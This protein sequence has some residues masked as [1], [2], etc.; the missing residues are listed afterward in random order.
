MPPG[1]AAGRVLSDRIVPEHDIAVVVGVA[2]TVF[3]LDPGAANHLARP[4]IAQALVGFIKSTEDQLAILVKGVQVSAHIALTGMGLV[5]CRTE[6]VVVAVDKVPTA[7][8]LTHLHIAGFAAASQQAAVLG[9]ADVDTVLAEVVVVAFHLLDASET[10]AIGVVGKAA[11]LI[12]PAALDLVDQGVAVLELSVG[13]LEVTACVLGI[14]RVDVGVQRKDFLIFLLLCEGVQ[15]AGAHEDTIRDIAHMHGFHLVSLLPDTVLGRQ[16]DAVDNAQGVRRGRI[17]RCRLVDPFQGQGQLIGLLVEFSAAQFEVV[18]DQLDF[19]VIHLKALIEGNDR[20]HPGHG[21]DTLGQLQQEGPCRSAFQVCTG[22]HVGQFLQTGGDRDLGHIQ[23]DDIGSNHILIRIDDAVEAAVLL[24]GIGHLAHPR[25]NTAAAGSLFK[26]EAVLALFIQCDIDARLRAGIADQA[27]R[28]GQRLDG[29][30]CR[31]MEV[32]TLHFAR[33]GTEG[34]LQVAGIDGNILALVAR[35]DG[36]FNHCTIHDVH[37]VLGEVQL[38][39]RSDLHRLAAN[40]HVIEHQLHRHRAAATAGQDALL[41]DRCP[42]LRHIQCPARSLGD[43][44][45]IARSADAGC[46]KLHRRTGRGV[47]IL[48]INQCM[49]E[50]SRAGRGGVHQQGRTDRA[51]EAVRRVVE[52]RELFGTRRLCNEGRGTAAVQVDR[53]HTACILHDL[54]DFNHAA[55][56]GARLLTAIQHHEHDLAAAGDADSRSGRTVCI[57]VAGCRNSQFAVLHQNGTEAADGFLDVIFVACPFGVAADDGSA[58]LGDGKEAVGTDRLVHVAVHH[59]QIAGFA[60]AHVEAAAI[61]RGNDIIVFDVE[62]AFRIAIQRLGTVGLI[63]YAGHTPLLGITALVVDHHA[64]VAS[65]DIR[66]GDVIHQLLAISSR[67]IVLGHAD[68]GGQGRGAGAEDGVVAVFQ[69]LHIVASQLAQ[70]IRKGVAAGP[71]QVAQ[72]AVEE[73]AGT[74]QGRDGLVAGIGIV[75]RGAHVIAGARAAQ[76]IGQ[77]VIRTLHIVQ[78]LGEVAGEQRRHI[79]G[80]VLGSVQLL[81]DVV[82]IQIAVHIRHV[83]GTFLGLVAVAAKVVFADVLGHVIDGDRITNTELIRSAQQVNNV[84]RPAANVRVI[85]AAFVVISNVHGAKHMAE[86]NLVAIGQ[87]EVLN[88]LQARHIDQDSACFLRGIDHILCLENKLGK[89]GVFIACHDAPGTGIVTVNA[90]TDV[91]DDQCHRILARILLGVHFRHHFQVVQVGQ[92]VVVI[93]NI[94]R[95]QRGNFHI[96]D[97][98]AA[99]DTFLMLLPA[100]VGVGGILGRHRLV[101]M[102]QGRNRIAGFLLVAVGAVGAAGRMAFPLAAGIDLLLG[103]LPVMTQRSLFDLGN[104]NLAANRAMRAFA[105]AGFLTGGEDCLIHND[106]MLLLLRIGQA[107]ALIDTGRGFVLAGIPLAPVVAS[108]R[109][110]LGFFQH[111]VTDRAVGTGAQTLLRT[112]G[113]NHLAHRLPIVH[114]HHFGDEVFADHGFAVLIHGGVG[115]S[116]GHR[117][118]LHAGMDGFFDAFIQGMGIGVD[119]DGFSLD[120]AAQDGLAVFIG[121]GHGTGEDRLAFR[122]TGRF[123]GQSTLI[124]G[125]LDHINNLLLNQH[126]STDFT[127]LA[128]GQTGGVAG[129]FNRRVDDLGMAGGKDHL[130]VGITAAAGEGLQAIL[131]AGGGRG[132]LLDVIMTG[133]FH[134]GVGVHVAAG[135]TGMRGIASLL[136]GGLSHHSVIAMAG[137]FHFGIGVYV[138][139]GRTGVRG[140]ASLLTGG[141]SRHGVIAVTGGGNHFGIDRLF[142]AAVAG[143]GEGLQAVFLTSSRRVDCFDVVMAER[144]RLAAALGVLAAAAMSA[145]LYAGV[146]TGC[147]LHSVDDHIVA[148][149]SNCFG[150]DRI[151]LTAVAGAGEGLHALQQTRGGEGDRFDMIVPNRINKVILVGIFADRTGIGRVT[152]LQTGGFGHCFVIG[153]TSRLNDLLSNQDFAADRAVGARRQTGAGTGGGNRRVDDLFMAVLRH[154]ITRTGIAADRTGIGGV[155]VLGTGGGS[156]DRSFTV[157]QGLNLVLS[158]QDFAADRAVG[159]L[160]QAGSRTGGGNRIIRHRSVAQGLNCITGVGVAAG[161]GV[162]GVAARG[163]GGGSHH[164]FMAVTQGLNHFRVGITTH[165]G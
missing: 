134:F 154:F 149:R 153:M 155:A 97:L 101:F 45:R 115:A 86:V 37:L 71:A 111:R 32:D 94:L 96:A 139:A 42:F 70:V 17:N 128:L 130:G 150:I 26:V 107:A 48:R 22:Q 50:R 15:A 53:R 62:F 59:Q 40:H 80:H 18:I 58:A 108:S 133:G 12:H 7:G 124:P 5:V 21:A 132:N 11:V 77:Q 117:A 72:V 55:A 131:R 88:V 135:R 24:A 68:T 151:L 16:L 145:S 27:C 164:G 92:E 9:L 143:A 43:R 136:T 137:G 49:V 105:P 91:L 39:G 63:Q 19:A 129:G 41:A 140:I 87:P 148:K 85:D 93:V 159:A 89:A 121:V 31:C 125:M 6:V 127:V 66:R 152:I 110:R 158:N 44:H 163:T 23:G 20:L 35:L 36:Q 161:T 67:C 119:G 76:T 116:V 54:G 99:V 162:G 81:H 47:V 144:R 122:H 38:V 52:H 69:I 138:A 60:R 28:N 65:G 95:G 56:D 142:L 147:F 14:I 1:N 29:A 98:V 82:G 112:G 118:F 79:A 57:V 3:H 4:V 104:Q 51:L 103:I 126:L 106:L 102:R 109:D 30:G 2:D 83:E 84:A 100:H 113:G 75:H 120:A 146:G 156:H 13:I 141:L 78:A 160:G 157:A 46:G 34:E 114:G 61:D 8:Q 123:L 10:R 33:F 64:N 25:Q 90:R 165:T 73:I 74:F